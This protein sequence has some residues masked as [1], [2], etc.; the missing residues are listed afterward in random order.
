MAFVGRST[1]AAIQR[2]VNPVYH[3]FMH[4]NRKQPLR[5]TYLGLDITGA[6]DHVRADKLIQVFVSKGIPGWLIEFVISFRSDRTTCLVIPGGKSGNFYVGCGLPQGSPLSPILFLLFASPLLEM[7][8]SDNRVTATGFS[9]DTS[10]VAVSE[11]Y[12]MNCLILAGAY[13]K[14]DE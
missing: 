14:I 1:T 5:A 12:Q 13:R 8:E 4:H 10:L 3:T 9:D 11:S 2:I 7:F 6:Y